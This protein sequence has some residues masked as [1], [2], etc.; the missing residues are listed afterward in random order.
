MR[1]PLHLVLCEGHFIWSEGR[2]VSDIICHIVGKID[3]MCNNDTEKD[4]KPQALGLKIA[5]RS[6]MLKLFFFL[7]AT[8]S[9]QQD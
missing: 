6:I 9:L 4:S 5:Q 7:Q 8:H 1:T 2:F 3:G